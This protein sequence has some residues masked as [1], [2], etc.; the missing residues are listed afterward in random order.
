M[1]EFSGLVDGFVGNVDAEAAEE[2][3]V[4]FG[5]NDRGMCVAAV[6][7]IEL[8]DGAGGAFVGNGADGQS[9]QRFIGVETGVMVAHMVHF[10]ML[11]RFDEFSADKFHFPIDSR[12]VFQRVEQASGGSTEKIGGFPRNDGAVGH[13]HGNGG[14]LGF[15]GFVYGGGNDGTIRRRNA[16]SFHQKFQ[17]ENFIGG[18]LPLALGATGVV[19]TADDL[20]FRGVAADFVIADT[21]ADHIHAHI[22]RGFIGTFAQNT[23]EH[24]VEHGEDLYVAV[25]VY[26]GFVIGFQM[27]GVDHIHIVEIDGSGF[28]SEVDG[29]IQRQIPNGECLEFSIAR[30]DTALTFMPDLAEASRHFA[31]AGA[32]SRYNDQGTIGF[33]IIIFSKAVFGK[34]KTDIGRIVGNDVVNIDRKTEIFEF[35]F[36]FHRRGLTAIL[37]DDDTAD[38]ETAIAERVDQAKSIEIVGDAEVTAALVAFDIIGADGDDDLRFVFHPHEHFY[39]GIGLEAGQNTA[40]VVIVEKFT[41]E[42]QIKLTAE[43]CDTLT[44]LG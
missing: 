18:V 25:I 30:F 21:Q 4:Y 29:M 11:D 31:A 5:E 28:V 22:R 42:L 23:L 1:I 3:F 34:N 6:E 15:L 8:I 13:F 12:K 10:E 36:E 20:P 40:G 2:V 16:A 27:E 33:D 26:R 38:I 37:S 14:I 19:I 44:N 43:T 9:D 24:R 7:E 39:F 35:F 17:F 32:G 41:A